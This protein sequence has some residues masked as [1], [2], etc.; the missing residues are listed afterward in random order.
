V[1]PLFVDLFVDAGCPFELKVVTKLADA[2]ISQLIQYLMLLDLR[3]GKLINFGGEQVEHK[4]VNCHESTEHR[5]RFQV[6]RNNWHKT[7]EATSF[8][9]IVVELTKDWGTGLSRSLYEE[10]FVHLFG[11]KGCVERMVETYWNGKTTGQQP[12]KMIDEGIAFEITCKR[13][14]LDL[15]ANHLY[16]LLNN[17]NLKSILWANIVSGSVRFEWIGK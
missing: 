16:K 15:Y 11:G 6:D 14:D 2:H 9:E 13:T 17:S 7:H 8:E 1:K 5:Q 12:F 10:A 3:H 4:F